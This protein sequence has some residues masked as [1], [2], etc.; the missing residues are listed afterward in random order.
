MSFQAFSGRRNAITIWPP[1]WMAGQGVNPVEIAM[2]KY[3]SGMWPFENMWTEDGGFRKNDERREVAEAFFAEIEEEKSLV[4]FYVDER[5]PLFV[6]DGERSAHRVLVG[7]S[8]VK[9]YEKDIHEWNETT[10]NGETNMVWSVPFRHSYPTDGIRLPVQA[11]ERAVPDLDA[12]S[13][14]LVPLDGGLRTDFRYGSSRITSDRA[15]AVV[16][17]AIASLARLEKDGA[18]ETSV[19]AELSWLNSVVLELWDDRGVYP[20]LPAL[21]SVLGCSRAVEIARTVVAEIGVEGR[22]E[23]AA[24]FD[25]LEGA[26]DSR[27]SSFSD[28]IAEAAAEWE[29]LAP[30]ARDLARLLVRMELTRD[31]MERVLAS[32]ESRARHGLPADAALIKDNP[33]IL[34]ESFVPLKEREPISFITVDHAL[35]PHE[36]RA[37]LEDGY[38][39]RRDPRRLRALLTGALHDAADG[40]HTFLA[41]LDALSAAADA[42]PP[43]RVCDVP[44]DRLAHEKVASILDETLDQF[45][46]E[47]TPYLALKDLHADEQ[48]VRDR[49]DSLAAR[50]PLSVETPD[51]QQLAEAAEGDEV[52][53][54]TQQHDAL[55]RS[56]TSPLSVITG[57]AGT[58]KSTLLAPLIA[59][60]RETEGMVPLRVLTPTGKA[61]DRLKELGVG[62]AMTIH[63]AL[64]SVG[65]YDWSLGIAREGEARIGAST[66]II[67]ECSMVNV[68]LLSTLFRA[69]DWQ[70]VRRMILVG[71][72]NQLPPIGPGRPFFDVIAVMQEGDDGKTERAAYS[73]RLSALTQN[74]RVEAGSNAITFAKSFADDPEPDDA[75]VWE[76]VA[77]GQDLGDLRVRYWND[78]AELYEQLLGEIDAL[79]TRECKQAHID[80][81]GS[82]AFDA[83]IGHGDSPYG[84]SEWQILAPMKGGPPGTRKLNALVQ[85]QYHGWA[86]RSSRYPGGAYKRWPVKFGPEQLTA[87]DKVMQTENTQLPYWE[88]GVKRAAGER[89]PKCAVFNGQIG[90][91][92]GESPRAVQRARRDDEK[93][94]V[95]GLNVEFEGLPGLRIDYYKD[96]SR[97]VDKHLQLAYAV[98][99]HKGQGSQFRH[100]MFVVPHE[101]A[102]HFGRELTYTGLT[103]AQDTLTLFVE[104]DIGPLLA[105]R[106]QAAAQ[107]PQRNSRLFTGQVGALPYRAGNVVYGTLRGDRVASKSELIIADLLLRYEEEGAL[108]YQYEREL[109]PP[110]GAQDSFRLP[111][112]T[113]SVAGRTYYWEHCGK[114]DDPAYRERWE[115]VRL[116]WYK[117]H[118]YADRLIVTE[119]GPTNPIDSGWLDREVV[120]KLILRS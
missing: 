44:L 96:G 22:D 4:F 94:P 5:N 74:Y 98:T 103:R 33:Y 80:L 3:S 47:E 95:T 71:D 50:E 117:R 76:A 57:A 43:D 24:V 106:K 69:I 36:S 63:R 35:V 41:A 115:R 87:F 67:D 32:P 88:P 61:A 28:E 77:S 73:D 112:F 86:K 110:D 39:A 105:L 82:R 26:A 14:Y 54:S 21:L 20:G 51:W 17:R 81:E 30:A 6:E 38:I 84:P 97:S 8:R 65:W 18:L 34:C 11:I 102:Q 72:H 19:A 85:D 90:L 37:P 48:N 2:D 60:I 83:T 9:S 75:I 53:L 16:E 100:V 101:A 40:G 55:D 108:S 64:A 89:R 99:V 62:D 79:V 116:P 70:T 92:R 109:F 12:R 29:Y 107:T 119:D 58:G 118:G 52:A 31:Q 7:I 114:M 120:Q 111:D 113:V 91:V 59:G 27:F 1:D 66:I 78:P 23:A 104:R 49:F 45:T 25:A 42:S 68:D 56:L 15:V 13:A 93:G 46:I 10:R